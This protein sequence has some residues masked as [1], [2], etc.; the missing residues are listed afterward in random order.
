MKIHHV[1][2]VSFHAN[3]QMDRQTDMTKLT[4]TFRNFAEVLSKRGK[5]PILKV[6]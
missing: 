2:A 3:G 6:P 1:E 5:L 4:V